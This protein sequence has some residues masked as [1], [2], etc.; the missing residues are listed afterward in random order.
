MV[1]ARCARPRLD[2][3]G[4]TQLSGDAR[5]FGDWDVLVAAA[6]AHGLAPLV[7]THTKAAGVVLPASAARSLGGLYLRHRQANQ[8]RLDAL[9]EILAALGAVGIPALVL[10]GAALA[11]LLYPEPGLRPMGD[12]D[13]LIDDTHF[14]PGLRALGDL[15]FIAPTPGG[16]SSTDKHLAVVKVVEGLPVGVEL[17][18]RLLAAQGP[19]T[20]AAAV[21]DP[22]LPFALGELTAYTLGREALLWHLCRHLVVHANVFTALRLIW[23]ADIVG[24]AELWAE[25]LDW[26]QIRTRHPLVP[27]VLSLLDS[28]T[29]LSPTV[30]E[31]AGIGATSAWDDFYGWPRSA[32]AD[33]RRHGKGFGQIVRDTF[34]PSHWWL[35]L[36]RGPG[37]AGPPAWYNRV[38]HVLEVLGW[39]G[40]LLVEQPGS[41]LP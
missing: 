41:F 28:I 36:H 30:R 17:H 16:E 35:R 11:H 39:I 23:V 24:L 19:A 9:A 1:L 15:G 10:K 21:A 5:G 22:P 33:Q 29:P 38:R 31:A 14:G 7:W 3:L 27:G 12:L 13:L 4:L 25:Q 2:A 40:H 34:L 20:S 32:L 26:R 18:R 8:I 6:E 37:T